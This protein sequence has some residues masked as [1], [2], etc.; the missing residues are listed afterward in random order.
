MKTEIL[1]FGI[2][3]IILTSVFISAASDLNPKDLNKAEILKTPQ[4]DPVVL[5]KN[6]QAIAEI[7]YGDKSGGLSKRATKELISAIKDSTGADIKIVDKLTEKPTLIIG[8]CPEAKEAGLDGAKMPIEGFE[9]K[10]A[11][12]RIFIVGNNDVGTAWGVIDF[13][14]RF[15]GV[16]FYWPGKLG[17]SIPKSKDL[18]I[19][20]AHIKDQPYFRKRE[21]Y[22]SGGR[23][24]TQ[25]VGPHHFRM[26]AYD[27][28]PIKLIV[29]GPH[30][31]SG[32]Y[33]KTRPEIF[34][35][36]NDGG[37]NFKM[38]CYGNPNTLQ[39]YLE[40]IELQLD[41]EAE[42]DRK[43]SIIRDK[44][45][46]VS[47]QD[48]AISCKCENCKELWNDKGG[49]YGTAS[50]IMVDFVTK[51]AVEVK[52]RWPD[53][54]VIFLP[55]KNYTYAPKNA[56]FPGNVEIQICGMPGLAQH[57]D[58]VINKEE[59]DNIDAWIDA[60]GRKI[61]NWHYNCWPADRTKAAYHYPHT[62]KKHYQANK[63]KTVGS[64]INGVKDHWPRQNF[65]L[66]TWLKVLWNPDFDVD[67]AYD[68]YCK[69]MFG[70]AEK[71]MKKMI[72]MQIDGWEKSNW[73]SHKF[74]PKSIYEE[75]FPRKDVLKMQKLFAKARK[76]AK[77]DPIVTARL[78]Y[79]APP[80]EEFFAESRLISEGIGLHTLKS[81]QVPEN[82]K[83]D[84]K[85]DDKQW[86]NVESFQFVVANKNNE[87]PKFTT[88]LKSVW[89][90]DGI[91]FAFKMDEPDPEQIAATYGAE[92]RDGSTIWWD[93]NVEIFLDVTAER[94][95]YYQFIINSNGA[96]F[97]SYV[98]D[99]SWNSKGI[100]AA[101]NIG[102]D[103]WTLEVYI[104]YSTFDKFLEPGTANKWFGNFTR[105]RVND[106]TDREYQRLNCNGSKSSSDQNAFGPIQ[107]IEQ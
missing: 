85:L 103:F 65:S 100:N 10:T 44:S 93:D 54:T 90:R 22:P 84:G 30:D 66:Y 5:V 45:I 47:P 6:G 4:H 43:G 55:Y 20:P 1:F 74:S 46:T 17:E 98:T 37:R 99:M 78:D 28:W 94:T 88:E 39:T 76:D 91:T 40:E 59:Q 61:Q 12:N 105:H 60:S 106:R 70:P 2:I 92:S 73:S 80:L 75:S 9:I 29:H 107:F 69:R 35:M 13:V 25:D 53:M 31:W 48:M 3:S 24:V 19:K 87:K 72:S 81:Y 79:L 26:R 64:F 8:D 42:T 89:T 41:P 33:S 86:E 58:E 11:P 82:P 27:S 101:S 96:I 49:T 15:M 67:A 16:R 38:L 57:K 71:N 63:D 77:K 7:Y 51:L 56:E 32:K 62:I 50:P 97:D 52:K 95:E 104:P 18:I 14:E 83:I 102:K 34:Q 23:S 36:A 68:E 21:I